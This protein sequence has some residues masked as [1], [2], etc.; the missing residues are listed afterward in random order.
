MPVF[1]EENKAGR[2]PGEIWHQSIE[3]GKEITEGSTIVLKYVPANVKVTV[4]NFVGMTKDEILKG[5]YNRSFDIR[6]EE[7]TEY[8]EG[9]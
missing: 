8:I 9:V 2:L 7:G 4:P 6:F 3:A 1:K 5:K